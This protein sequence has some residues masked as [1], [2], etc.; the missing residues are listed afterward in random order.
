VPPAQ[1]TAFNAINLQGQLAKKRCKKCVFF[2]D[3]PR[4]ESN[5]MMTFNL[6]ELFGDEVRQR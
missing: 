4:F 6:F 1:L 2:S 5:D 3:Q